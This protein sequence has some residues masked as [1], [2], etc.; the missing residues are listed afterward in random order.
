MCTVTGYIKA[1]VNCKMGS[2]YKMMS[3]NHSL[4]FKGAFFLP[5]PCTL[6]LYDQVQQPNHFQMFGCECLLVKMLTVFASLG[7]G[8]QVSRVTSVH[9]NHTHNTYEQV[10]IVITKAWFP[11]LPIF[12]TLY[13][14]ITQQ[15]KIISLTVNDIWWAGGKGDSDLMSLLESHLQLHSW[16]GLL[17][18]SCIDL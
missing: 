16:T 3:K 13:S 12:I 18:C 14:H 6:Q 4:Y 2:I 17:R 11:V 5:R 8:I 1:V 10:D 9:A 15:W 7:L